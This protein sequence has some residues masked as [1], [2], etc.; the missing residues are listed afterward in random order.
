MNPSLVAGLS[1]TALLWL[2]GSA[3]AGYEEGL[4]AYAAKD[5]KSAAEEW[6]TPELEENSAAMFALGVMYMRGQGVGKDQKKG[7]E[8][9]LKSASMGFSSAQ[10]N[11]GLAYFAGKGVPQDIEKSRYWWRQAAEQNHPAAQ[12]NL[13]AILWSGNGT[14]QDQAGAMHWF[15]KAKVNGNKDASTFLLTL[16]APMYKE[17]NAENLKLANDASEHNIPLIDQ[18]GM[19][20]LGLQA[21]EK[22]QYE[23]AFAYWEPLARDG[24]LD[25]Q[26]QIGRLYE[27]G[28]GVGE[29]FNMALEWYQRAAQK[30]QGD[31]QFR[32]GLYHMNENPDKNEALGFY[33]IQ[34]AADN[35]S[36]QAKSYIDN[37]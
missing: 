37:M 3:Y 27:R 13:G 23:Q 32:I 33:W 5:F 9:Y 31:A 1:F 8:Y 22:Q 34:S 4:R 25:S 26:Y 29:D 2:Y 20:K 36:D 21:T 35:G 17:L 14:V 18:F 6:S 24:H 10:Y 11:L 28:E 19:Y 30:G 7:A 16:F 12:Y 15:R